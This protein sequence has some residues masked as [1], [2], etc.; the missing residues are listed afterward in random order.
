MEPDGRWYD[1]G[2]IHR[3]TEFTVLI[4]TENGMMKLTL[5]C[6]P[7]ER[8]FHRSPPDREKFLYSTGSGKFMKRVAMP[9]DEN[10]WRICLAGKNADRK[11]PGRPPAGR[12]IAPRKKGYTR[13]DIRMD[14]KT[15]K[16]FVLEANAQC[17]ISED[18]NYT[19]IGAILRLSGKTF[20]KLVLEILHDAWIRCEKQKLKPIG[21]WK[22]CPCLNT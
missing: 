14:N 11:P 9:G 16:L 19:S 2:R 18:E 4:A 21:R 22:Q 3:R 15:G 1:S 20:S 7:V 12:H 5:L 8:V 13:I 10:F 17:R 6:T